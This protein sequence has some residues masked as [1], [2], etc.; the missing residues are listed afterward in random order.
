M[1]GAAP[2][3]VHDLDHRLV[4]GMTR[5]QLQA[6]INDVEDLGWHEAIGREWRRRGERMVQ[7]IIRAD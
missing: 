3:R 5:D 1:A 2:I 7:E 4:Q 6:L